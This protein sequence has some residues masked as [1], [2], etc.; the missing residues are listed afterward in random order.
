MVNAKAN[1]LQ[2]QAAKLDSFDVLMELAR[3]ML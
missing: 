3:T 2:F 1:A